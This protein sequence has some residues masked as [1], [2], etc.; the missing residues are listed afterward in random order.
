MPKSIFKDIYHDLKR[1]I[2]NGT[3]A[4]QDFLPSEAELTATYNC[5]RSA[6]RRALSILALDGYVQSQQGKGVRV[7]RDSSMSTQSP[8]DGL[9][10]FRESAQRRGLTPRTETVIFETIVAD[11]ALASLTGFSA[12]ATLLHILRIRR[13][14][15]EA[16]GTDESYYPAERVT[17]LTPEIANGSTF[18]YLEETLGIKIVTSKRHITMERATEHDKRTIDLN[19]FNAVAVLRGNSF[20]EQGLMIEY[21]ETRL[22]P[23]FFSLYQ[24]AIRPAV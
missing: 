18:A 24:T 12:E 2:D 10:T 16:V 3:F 22:R 13:A 23:E 19:G 8:Y 21:S 15:E 5:S 20:D 4:Y 7:I 6:V 1:Q 14:N 11:E 9:I 17:G